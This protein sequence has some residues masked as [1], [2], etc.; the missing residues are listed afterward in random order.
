MRENDWIKF[1]ESECRIV[2]I[3]GDISGFKAW[4][5]RSGRDNLR[6]TFINIAREWRIFRT[7]A[8]M[9][10]TLGDGF[11]AIYEIDETSGYKVA[12][13]ILKK[14]VRIC[15]KINKIIDNSLSPRPRGFR[16]RI[17]EGDGLRYRE[18]YTDAETYDY[19]SYYINMTKELLRVQEDV[20]VIVH[21]NFKELLNGR[22]RSLGLQFKDLPKPSVRGTDIFDEDL[23]MLWRVNK[24]KRK[25]TL[26]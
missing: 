15:A 3:F 6:K 1:H 13:C 7:Y 2:V 5:K 16:M 21:E 20:Q 17:A 10:K 23:E 9:Y 19:L 26:K 24:R 14:A 4:M 18:K 25:R 22:A 11:M 8:Q 12:S